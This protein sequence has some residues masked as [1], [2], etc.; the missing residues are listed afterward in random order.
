MKKLNAILFLCIM[1][2]LQ[3]KAQDWTGNVYQIGK[4]YPGY[5]VTN[6][7]D[8]IEG[9]F[10]H[11]TQT[12][13][14]KNCH[15][16]KAETDAKPT[17]KFGPEDIKA[18]KVA[19]KVYRSIHYSGGLLAKPLRFNLV[20]T[21]GAIT[22]FIFYDEMGTGETKMVYH[23]P[24]DANNA[25]PVELQSFGLKF[26]KKMSEYVADYAELS[27]KI[28]DKADGYGMLKILEIIKEYN[29]WYA[30]K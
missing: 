2:F 16:Y 12:S 5:Y 19:D 20:T 24:H 13:N 8:T 10:Y 23:K 22:E 14:Q 28:A 21:D 9:Y 15:Y 29:D 25:Q 7:G 3:G 17:S 6:G 26:A 1:P 4:I 18:Y 11:G 30:K 27:K